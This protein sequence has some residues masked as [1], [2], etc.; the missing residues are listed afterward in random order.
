M[1]LTTAKNPG[2]DDFLGSVRN[3]PNNNFQH[4]LKEIKLLT[5][6]TNQNK[7]NNNRSLILEFSYLKQAGCIEMIL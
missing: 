2:K 5:L 3:I 7:C 4:L 6:F 1:N